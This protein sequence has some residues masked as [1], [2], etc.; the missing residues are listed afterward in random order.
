MNPDDVHGFPSVE[1]VYTLKSIVG[2]RV[3]V[4]PTY[5]SS[6]L[7]EFVTHFSGAF[8][9]IVAHTPVINGLTDSFGIWYFKPEEGP[10][11]VIPIDPMDVVFVDED[12]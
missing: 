12:Y 8:G 6:N 9:T 11:M 5:T 7:N 1:I 4:S 2:R 3:Q 10:G